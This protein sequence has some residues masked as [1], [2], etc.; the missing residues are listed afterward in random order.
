[1]ASAAAPRLLPALRARP[2]SSPPSCL[3]R[4]RRSRSSHA[5]RPQTARQATRPA[6]RAFSATRARPTDGVFRGLSDTRLPIPW[7]EAFRLQQE[8]QKLEFAEAHH[9]ERDLT[10]KPMRDSY[11]RVVSDW[12]AELSGT[13][14]I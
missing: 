12:P 9:Q 8:G 14:A 6:A 13:C 4:S 11:H 10:P 3:C 7:I 5:S 2:V 1:M